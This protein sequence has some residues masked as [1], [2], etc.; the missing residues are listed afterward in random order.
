[1]QSLL[2]L[3]R[4]P[5]LGVAELESL[6]G[7]EKVRQLT[8]AAVVDVD[9]C[10]LSFSRLGGAVKFGKVLTVLPT[11]NW[12]AIENYLVSVSPEHATQMPAGKM[13]L[14]VSSYGFEVTAR[15]VSATALN[16]KKAI[17]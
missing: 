11:T 9:P 12:Q 10:L 3:G 2:I 1:M 6:Y 4:Q 16:I 7:A 15:R 8:G 17:V 5:A 14:G 13:T